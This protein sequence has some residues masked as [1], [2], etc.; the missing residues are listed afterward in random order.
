ME[1]AKKAESWFSK[2]ASLP[3][4][5]LEMAGYRLYAPLSP[6]ACC[7]PMG[8]DPYVEHREALAAHNRQLRAWTANCPENFENRAA[9][10]GA[11]IA[12]IEGRPLEAMDLYERAIRSARTNGFVHQEAL[13]SEFAA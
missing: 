2:S 9:L 11:E 10:V 7:E 5:L 1:A 8:P 13:A 6:A 3:I 12:R 4:F